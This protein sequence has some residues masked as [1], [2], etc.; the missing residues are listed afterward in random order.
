MDSNRLLL[1]GT[2]LLAVL[3]F[4]F[5]PTFIAFARN[6]PDRRLLA[7]LN[8]LS[9]LSFLLWFALLAWA[10]GGQ[11]NDGIIGRFVGNPGNRK[12]LFALVAILV[13]IGVSTT[14]YA[15]ITQ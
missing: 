12:R 5:L 3:A 8:L 7:S 11:R 15:L 6:H 9:L 14:A 4:N 13:G 2:V 10:L 1:F